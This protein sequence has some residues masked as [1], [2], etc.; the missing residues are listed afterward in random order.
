MNQ[1]RDF[2]LPENT[3]KL[4]A[5]SD[6]ASAKQSSIDLE[7][8]FSKD[9]RENLEFEIVFITLVTTAVLSVP[10]TN[11]LLDPIAVMSVF[12]LIL[13]TVVRRMAVGNSWVD[14][15][16]IY[17]TTFGWVY[18]ITIFSISY[19]VLSVCQWFVSKIVGAGLLHV[20]YLLWGI[21]LVV[22]SVLIVVLYELNFRDFIFWAAVLFYNN[23]VKNGPFSR[24]W[25]IFSNVMLNE[26]ASEMNQKH[27]AIMKI[28]HHYQGDQNEGIE[29]VGGKGLFAI[30]LFI[31]LLIGAFFSYPY[32]A[33][34][35]SP[36][37][38]ISI[39]MSTWISAT[40][41]MTAI[42]SFFYQRYGT[43]SYEQ[44]PLWTRGFAIVYAILFIHTIN[45][46]GWT[47][48]QVQLIPPLI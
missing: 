14:T 6:R 13:L 17:R 40:L 41:T 29:I 39:V 38:A 10:N 34:F 11:T 32:S 18:L 8:L 15:G 43:T 31:I 3:P 22:V 24:F 7:F 35:G 33:F 42:L 45:V 1:E 48:S 36:L 9:A 5:Q 21:A 44:T 26:S 19:S 37:L 47:I 28:R 20:T 16:S 4:L 2:Q 25:L 12:T 23:S 27:Y 46:A 30:V